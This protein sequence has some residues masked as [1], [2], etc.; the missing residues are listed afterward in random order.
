MASPTTSNQQP[1]PSQAPT[2]GVGATPARQAAQR[3]GTA[4]YPPRVG[5]MQPSMTGVMQSQETL[6]AEPI[7][8]EDLDVTLLARVY[9]HT[10]T[11]ANSE[12][13]ALA[14]EQ[15][16]RTREEALAVRANMDEDAPQPESGT[17][18]APTNQPS[19]TRPQTAPARPGE[20][21]LHGHPTA[22]GTAFPPQQRAGDTPQYAPTGQPS[23]TGQSADRRQETEQHERDKAKAKEAKDDDKDDKDDKNGKRSSREA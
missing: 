4:A 14:L 5:G 19:S 22:A 21:G 18:A 20:A 3:E 17:A 16:N 8:F 10:F 12:A 15:G 9:P 7:L 6:G 1:L 13:G 23:E 11:A 2:P